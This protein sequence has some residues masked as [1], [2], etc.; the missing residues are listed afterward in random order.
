MHTE[1]KEENIPLSNE[2]NQTPK[3]IKEGYVPVYERVKGGCDMHVGLIYLFI[4]C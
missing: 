4:W 1:Q 2:D 3:P